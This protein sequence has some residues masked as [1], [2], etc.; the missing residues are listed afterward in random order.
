M[1]GVNGL[2]DSKTSMI[3][4]FVPA[5]AVDTYPIGDPFLYTGRGRWPRCLPGDPSQFH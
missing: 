1:L 4:V 3:V 5:H 2:E